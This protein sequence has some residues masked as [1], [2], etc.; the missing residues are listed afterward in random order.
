MIPDS[1]PGVCLVVVSVEMTERQQDVADHTRSLVILADQLSGRFRQ[2]DMQ[3]A[4]GPEKGVVYAKQ[5][6]GNPGKVYS[7]AQSLN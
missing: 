5:S 2:N 4:T 7:S 6:C 1:E 3:D